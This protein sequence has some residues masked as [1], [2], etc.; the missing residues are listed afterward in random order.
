MAGQVADAM[1]L[2][3]QPAMLVPAGALVVAMLVFLAAIRR[4]FRGRAVA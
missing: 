3:R 4:H 2:Y 1:E